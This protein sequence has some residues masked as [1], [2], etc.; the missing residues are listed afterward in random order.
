MIAASKPLRDGAMDF[1]GKKSVKSEPTKEVK[2]PANEVKEESVKEQP[3]DSNIQRKPASTKS[4]RRVIE[5]DDEDDE[6]PSKPTSKPA[7]KPTSKSSSSS[8]KGSSKNALEPTSSMVRAEDQAAMEAMMAMDV[9]D[10]EDDD[11]ED[12]KPKPKP[13]GTRKRK[14]RQVKKSKQELDSKGYMGR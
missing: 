12:T 13:S 2:K 14:R 8:G 10:F 9:D 7:S 5:S 3:K 4:R 1:S 11:L 6:P